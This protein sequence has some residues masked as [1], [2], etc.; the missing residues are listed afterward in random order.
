[1]PHAA[2]TIASEGTLAAA[3]ALSRSYL[4]VHPGHHFH[5]IVVGAV[6]AVASL[7][8]RIRL[9]PAMDV[10]VPRPGTFRY[11]Y[12]AEQACAALKPHAMAWLLATAAADGL[13]YLGP[14]TYV[15]APMEA[16]WAA[17]A[18]AGVLLAPRLRA[19]FGDGEFRAENAIGRL[20]GVFDNAFLGV[21]RTPGTQR[22]L[23]W[24]ARELFVD[25]VDAP[26]AGRY[27]DRRCLDPV[28]WLF[29][30]VQVLRDP[31]YGVAPWNLHEASLEVAGDAVLVDGAPLVSFDFSGRDASPRGEL[32]SAATVVRVD[33]LPA[34]GRLLSIR[35]AAVVA[36]RHAL[37]P[38][39]APDPTRLGN[40]IP[41]VR[42]LSAV[43]LQSARRGLRFPEPGNDPDGFCAFAARPDPSP[44]GAPVAPLA[45]ALL[46]LR[47][48]VAAAFPRAG[49][50]PSDPGFLGWLRDHGARE[51]GLG[52]YLAQFGAQLGAVHPVARALELRAGRPDLAAAFAVFDEVQAHRD[53]ARWL[54]VHGPAEAGLDP[55]VA[56]AFARTEG[57]MAR[58]L[59][60]W[61][62]QPA[63][64]MEPALPHTQAQQDHIVRTLAAELWRLPGIDAGDLHYFA[65]AA[66]ERREALLLCWLR[67]NPAVRRAI[68]GA[69]SIF[70][71][72]AL[73]RFL[74]EQGASAFWPAVA[75]ALLSPGYVPA[76][77][78]VAGVVADAPA[79]R[80]LFPDAPHDARA[81][82]ERAH[83]VLDEFGMD[84]R[85]PGW[86][87]WA[88][89]VLATAGQAPAPWLN[90]CGPLRD[91][92]GV[93][94]A[95]RALLRA[96]DAAGVM[97][98][99]AVMPGAGAGRETSATEPALY[100]S[101]DPAASANLLVA[102]A[103]ARIS[104]ELWFG[105]QF[106]A[107]QSRIAVWM[108]ETER[109][110]AR[111]R[112]AAAGLDAIIAPS[113]FVAQA[114][115]A[116]VDVPVHVVPLPP[117]FDALARAAPDRARFSV[118]ENAF[119]LGYFF[120]A[121]SVLE[122][123]N[124][125]AVID[126][127][128]MAFGGREDACL[129]LKV[130]SPPVGDYDYARL[131]Q[132][133][134]GLNVTWIEDTLSRQDTYALMASL[135]AYVSLHRAEGFGLTLAEAMAL[136]KPCIAT[137]YSGNLDFM[138]GH[139]ALLV[140]HRRI[141][142]RRPHGAYPAGSRWSEP[143]IEDAAR[144]MRELRE[145]PEHRA[146]I[147]N[148]ARAHVLRVL[149]PVAVGQRLARACRH[150][151]G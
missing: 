145:D 101:V 113:R 59:D 29:E 135:D 78:Q 3:L 46:A 139:C 14:E 9:V 23:D 60:A 104:A 33:E 109:L 4:A 1:M 36:S 64:A 16:A 44:F 5:L 17:L 26:A 22:M 149:D 121:N 25:C 76:H 8:P 134:A 116:T 13:L 24:W 37:R 18:E 95:A 55:S 128:R 115:R 28:P 91:A 41:M 11:Q 147:G 19:A 32:R 54:A 97:H 80:A 136:G 114:I 100:G 127:F 118:P 39:P 86:P 47:P 52:P 50:D 70:R 84:D 105:D 99:R 151:A 142:T 48:D 15:F 144:H 77:A 148:A 117:D 53:Y 79:V 69:P 83:Y 87:G 93:G 7:D 66:R 129:V 125:A 68:G 20:Q 106:L 74:E 133:A 42:A 21:R 103:D 67:Y 65:G 82:L 12:T 138:D 131:V 90:V 2:F 57:A 58:V 73:R 140:R 30:G 107:G 146:R 27:L 143:S 132:R 108:W 45:S 49:D 35:D 122:R 85:Q 111:F 56:T 81:A 96:L 88:H 89:Q 119:V 38:S 43:A 51:E 141:T 40:G 126:A 34:L 94:E 102:N 130:N 62:S 92:S 110:P 71:H 63:H 98:S 10:P 150:P 123:K 72:A 31:A 124:P 120:D 61:F 137:G 112:E 6:P 75:G